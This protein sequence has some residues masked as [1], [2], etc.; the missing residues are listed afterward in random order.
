MFKKKIILNLI[1]RIKILIMNFIK[2]RPIQYGTSENYK[3]YV[4]TN[5][6]FYI[7]PSNFYSSLA[8][9]KKITM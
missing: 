4:K 9:S 5:N 2:L 8:Q 1:D 6:A 3:V 7:L